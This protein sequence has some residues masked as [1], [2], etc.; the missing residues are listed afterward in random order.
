ML[1][2][3]VAGGLC[4]GAMLCGAAGLALAD[5]ADPAPPNCTAADLAQVA[6]GVAAAT[7]DYLFAHPDVNDFFTSQKG[8]TPDEL[9]DSLQTYMDANPQTHA[10]LK[11]IRQPLFDQRTR[12][13][14]DPDAGLLGGQ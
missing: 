3:V 14:E 2:G 5:P 12:C 7:S 10:E 9:R 11:A 4:A 6:A 13:G 1:R 8:K